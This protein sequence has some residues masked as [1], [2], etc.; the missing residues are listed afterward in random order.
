M[1]GLFLILGLIALTHC[2]SA[3]QL[4]LPE[5]C[6]DVFTQDQ[7]DKLRAIAKKF[8]E[9]AADLNNA[10][11][12]AAKKHLQNA[13][14]ILAFVQEYLVTHAKD[15]KCESVLTAETCTKLKKIGELMQ[16]KAEQVNVAIR[17]AIAHGATNAKEIYQ[18][19]KDY[20][21]DVLSRTKC[22]DWLKA[23]TCTKIKDFASMTHIRA[24]EVI[25]AI[26]EAVIEGAANINDIYQKAIDFL[27]DEITCEGI[28]GAPT[29]EKLE[30]AA[31]MLGE[32]ATAV[33]EAIKAAV[34]AHKQK[35][36]EVLEFVQQYLVDKAV[37][38][39]CENVL[40]AELCAK[41]MVIGGHFKDSVATI[42]KAIKE[43]VV[44]GASGVQE[45]YNVAIAWLR[46]NVVAKK[47]EDLISADLCQ[48][49][50][51]F[52]TKVHVNAQDVLQAV[53]EAIAAGAWKPSELYKKAVE[54]LKSKISCEAVMGKSV[55]D[56]IRA[57][58]DKFSVSLAKVD[59]V[60]RNAIASG[61]TKV[62]DLYKVVVKYI[63]D[64][65]T[66]LIGDEEVYEITEKREITGS[67][68]E[69]L[70]KVVN[71]VLEELNVVNE[72]VKQKIRELVVKGKVSIFKLKEKINQ[73]LAEII[74]QSDD[75]VEMTKRGLREDL[76][77]ILDQ[78][79]GRMKAL[80]EQL[81]KL[82]KEKLEQAKELIKKILEKFGMD[83]D[84]FI[85]VMLDSTHEQI[86]R[87]MNEETTF[88]TDMIIADMHEEAEFL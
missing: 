39:K 54:Y 41:I 47:C 63:M 44:H 6:E 80:I 17:E 20:I 22:E 40:S 19:A 13:K 18:K 15:F 33:T 70:L 4:A 62:K 23:D 16:V 3:Q 76:Q 53:K 38:F 57:L 58:A 28:L 8:G 65:W 29:C 30:R 75:E 34:K 32:K 81:L 48:K 43:A 9:S 2:A 84:S 50:R 11:K 10:I 79:K 45:I 78:A 61:V 64:K 83:E 71:K 42:N 27:T 51:D 5:K 72:K 35:V 67:L 74:N 87:E 88:F 85:D 26:R 49:I 46:K 7:C 77:A 59:E 73:L 60:L 36:S 21:R 25:K 1:K 24:T 86:L 31:Q 12:E 52:A 66:D 56:R 55:C 69:A 14:D 68:K 37:N 82:S